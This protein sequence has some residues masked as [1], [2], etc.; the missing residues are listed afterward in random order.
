MRAGQGKTGSRMIECRAQ[1]RRGGM[2]HGAIRRERSRNVGR[3]GSALIIGLMAINTSGTGKV[4]VVIH[5]AGS[6]CH[7][8]VRARQRKSR[9]RM[10]EGCIRPG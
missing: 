6:A 9:K 8:H 7:R 5:V 1:P 4:V 2:A 10:V 3:I